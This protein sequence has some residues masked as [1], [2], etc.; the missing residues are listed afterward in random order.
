MA[1][2][3]VRFDWAM[4]RLL[5]NKANFDILEGLLAELLYEDVKIRQLLESE[6]NKQTEDDKFNRVDILVENT[7]GELV[8]IEIQNTREADYFQRMLYGTAKV[9]V[10]HIAEGQPYSQVKK[11]YSVNIVYFDLGQGDDYVYHGTTT[12]VGIHSHRELALSDKQKALFNKTSV[13]DLYPTYY[14]IKTN[15]FNEIARDT[16]DEWIYFLKTAEIRDEF[17]AKG[18][19]AA[20]QK[21]DILKLDPADRQ[22]Y[23]RYLEAQRS[24]ASF[25]ETVQLEISSAVNEALLAEKSKIAENAL[26]A[27]LSVEV[28]AQITGLSVERIQEIA[29]GIKAA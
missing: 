4:K 19:K 18:L 7:K 16:L 17:T 5:R 24:D 22:D 1:K 8:I 28:V 15:R 27:G 23:D 20:S 3:L 26:I 10:E 11:V 29:D 14:V 9:I 2:K 25:V 6:G 13:S 12:F 21:L